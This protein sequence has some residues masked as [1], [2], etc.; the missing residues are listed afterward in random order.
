MTLQLEFFSLTLCSN[1]VKQTRTSN[2]TKY[3]ER[4]VNNVAKQGRRKQSILRILVLLNPLSLQ[5]VRLELKVTTKG[6]LRKWLTCLRQS[7]LAHQAA[8]ESKIINSDLLRATNT[9]THITYS[10]LCT[11]PHLDKGYFEPFTAKIHRHYGRS[12]FSPQTGKV[13]KA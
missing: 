1:V 13:K 9:I 4:K 5:C 6:S 12:G 8:V 7:P 3:Q 10:T 11:I 2:T